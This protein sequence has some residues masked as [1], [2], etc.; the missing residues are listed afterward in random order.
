MLQ[1][2]SCPFFRCLLFVSV[3]TLAVGG[4]LFANDLETLSEKYRQARST[5]G[6]PGAP[7]GIR[8]GPD[9]A[10]LAVN[11]PDASFAASP[12]LAGDDLPAR[13]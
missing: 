11:T 1:M 2:P 7:A 5:A 9:C 10:L 6:R 12:A 3:F 4:G 13:R 8:A